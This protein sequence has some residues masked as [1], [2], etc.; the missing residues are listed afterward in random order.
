MT[1]AAMLLASGCT[2]SS[3]V[4]DS[5]CLTTSPTRLTAAE[6]DALSDVTARAILAQNEFWQERCGK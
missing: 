4:P 3:S 1:L 2:T 5:L 6:I